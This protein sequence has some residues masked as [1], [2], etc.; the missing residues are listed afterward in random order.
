[1]ADKNTDPTSS[2]GEAG[3]HALSLEY[4]V[5]LEKNPWRYSNMLEIPA[6]DAATEG[7]EEDSNNDVSKSPRE[8]H[9][10]SKKTTIP[11]LSWV[12]FQYAIGFWK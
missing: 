12:K 7:G 1:M 11:V 2:S 8:N 10:Q 5:E 4:L 6:C 3:V 9:V